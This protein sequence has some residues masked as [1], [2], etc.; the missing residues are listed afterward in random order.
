MKS[1]SSMKYLGFQFFIAINNI[2]PK[3]FSLYYSDNNLFCQKLPSKG[4]TT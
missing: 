4:S 2:F 1:S 3:E